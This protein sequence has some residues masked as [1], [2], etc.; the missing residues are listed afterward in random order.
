MDIELNR[1]LST[2]AAGVINAGFHPCNAGDEISLE[3]AHW[4]GQTVKVWR[5]FAAKHGADADSLKK[6]VRERKSKH[7][8]K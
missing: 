4:N 3:D 2:M 7:V 8:G 6:W 1:L 5:L